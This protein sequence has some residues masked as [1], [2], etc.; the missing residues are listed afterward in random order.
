[1]QRLFTK[2]NENSTNDSKH[3]RQEKTKQNK[4]KQQQ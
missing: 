3:F 4:T 1:M 2:D